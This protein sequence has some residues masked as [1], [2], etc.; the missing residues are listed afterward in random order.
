MY[1]YNLGIYMR[2]NIDRFLPYFRINS[3]NTRSGN[4]YVPATHRLTLTQ[5]QSIFHQAPIN[6]ELVPASTTNSVTLP[7]FKR[8]YRSH[9]ISQYS[10]K[11]HGQY[12]F[13]SLE[14]KMNGKFVVVEDGIRVE[15]GRTLIVPNTLMPESL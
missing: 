14:K 6:W 15:C 2:K 13:F 8:M 5:N 4:Y 9:L 7:S 3:S 1:K 10:T 12:F 11:E